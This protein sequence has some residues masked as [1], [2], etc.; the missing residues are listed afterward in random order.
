VYTQSE[1]ENGHFRVEE[2]AKR[3]KRDK[4][5]KDKLRLRQRDG[6]GSGGGDKDD[7]DTGTSVVL[8]ASFPLHLFFE[9]GSK[10][11][12][13]TSGFA[14]LFQSVV[15]VWIQTGIKYHFESQLRDEN[16][17]LVALATSGCDVNERER[18]LLYD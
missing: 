17:I 3:D 10:A 5:H 1:L 15:N 16:T 8:W 4:S 18:A 12:G 9:A 2:S 7:H 13:L 14:Q 11:E 6:G